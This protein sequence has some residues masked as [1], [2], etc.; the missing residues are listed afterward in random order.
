MP[1]QR[2]LGNGMDYADVTSLYS[3]VDG[4]QE[5]PE[6]ANELGD[7][8]IER[9]Q[10]ALNNGHLLTARSWYFLAAACYR[11]GQSP[12]PD[13]DPL[14]KF[15]YEQL[16]DAYGRAGALSSPAFEHIEVKGLEGPMFG[17]LIRPSES[18]SQ[19]RDPAVVVVVG[20]F[21]GWREEYHTGAMYLV[22][23]GLAVLLIDGPGQGESRVLGNAH[24]NTDVARAFSAVIDHLYKDE[25]IQPRVGLWG[26]S[27]GG[28]LAA[29]AASTDSRVAACCV[30]GGTTRPAEI[31]DRY[32]RFINKVMPL[33]GIYEPASAKNEIEKFVLTPQ[34]LGQ[35]RCPL[36]VLHGTPDQ[37]FL[38]DNARLLHAGAASE[39]KTFLEWPDGD[40]CIYNHSHE[41]HVL[42]ADWF[43]D[44]LNNGGARTKHTSDSV[45]DSN[46]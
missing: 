15:L 14:K 37:I 26:N 32:P 22:E 45:K 34:A 25:R 33:L 31:L 23:R 18:Q 13:T 36:L 9:A 39:D 19:G 10:R 2:L 24:M 43:S 17:W 29:L 20:G 8:N 6:A 21:D 27:M 7:Q 28:Y 44:Q 41:K 11:V 35:L 30:N 40:H 46:A 5:W 12:L 3:K 1:L 38:V 4:G 16:I 42:I